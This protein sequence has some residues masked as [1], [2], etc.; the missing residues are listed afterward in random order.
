MREEHATRGLAPGRMSVGRY[1]A[2]E[3]T[4]RSQGEECA[5]TLYRPLVQGEGAA[6]CVV[7]APGFSLTRRDTFSRIGT[8]FAEAG[9]AALT[10]DFR[11][12]GDS[13]GEPRQFFDVDQQRADFAAAVACVRTLEGI[14]PDRV[15]AW[16][17]S[18][19]GGV[20]LYH[21]ATDDRLAAAIAVCP[22]V[23]GLAMMVEAVPRT[24][25]R[26]IAAVL[27]AFVGRR[28]LR[29]PAVGP[30]GALA[31]LT[32]PEVIPGVE[33]LRGEGSRWQNEVLAQPTQP[34]PVIRPVR[35]ARRVRCP[36]LIVNA[37]NDTVVAA[38]PMLRAA[39][40]AEKGE[41]CRYP[42]NHFEPLLDGLD[43]LIEDQ[44]GFLRRHLEL[45]AHEEAQPWI[46]RA[47]RGDRASAGR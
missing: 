38:R 2:E 28:T 45:T 8:R 39:V 7:I 37:T 4:F 33:A 12:F 41:L 17:Y 42:L 36:L 46:D 10:F 40:R 43:A 6:P 47:R 23:D 30:P 26:L 5:A 16:G 29:L 25:R 27:R 19:G 14:D 34:M 3:L 20:A 9:F 15:V 32:K 18:M 11:H 1:A 21:A 22:M 44:L 24:R 13:G 31:V 35:H